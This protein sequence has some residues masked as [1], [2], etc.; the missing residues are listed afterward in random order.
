VKGVLASLLAQLVSLVVLI[1][2]VVIRYGTPPQTY[3][4]LPVLIALQVMAMIGLAYI[5][6]AA[7]V[8][9]RDLKDFVQLFATAGVYLLPI[10]YLPQWVPSMFA[11]LLY[12]NPFSYMVWCY[13]DALYFGR[14]AHP[15]AWLV[16]S[17]GSV[18]TFV[19]G[20][21]VFRRLKPGLGNLL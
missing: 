14:F 13:Q 1:V 20:Y 8:Y 9:F 18:G 21:R 7:G 17:G 11:P 4:L 19:I 15:W 5:L 12:L 3:L 6:S 16:M 2:Y 10:F